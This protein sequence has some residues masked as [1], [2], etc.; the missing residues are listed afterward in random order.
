MK[1]YETI[2][3]AI[4]I[5]F[6][7][8]T[9]QAAEI[10]VLCSNGLRE[11]VQELG[12]Q[13]ER[14]SDHKLNITFGLASRFK[15]QIEGG[16]AFDVTVL[17]PAFVD[18]LIKQGKIVPDSRTVIARTGMGILT[19]KG[20][21]KP[22]ISTGDAFK[23]MLIN[24]KAFAY[25][26]EGAS[27]AIFLSLIERLGLAETLKPK[28]KP[29]PN[30]AAVEAIVEKGEAEFGVLPISEILPAHGIELVAPFPAEV[31]S[32]LLMTAGVGAKAKEPLAARDLLKHLTAPT[33]HPAIKAKG[34]E[35]G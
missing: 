32:H 24:T 8:A 28:L 14:A 26:S 12:P 23:R 33:N 4:A 21:P 9:A 22:D 5:A 2:G 20:G 13:F 34:M 15:Q 10:R 1:A 25:P 35:P 11:V 17:T 19:R 29:V 16:E 18:E 31:Q 30:A 7:C 3:A 6:A 27:G